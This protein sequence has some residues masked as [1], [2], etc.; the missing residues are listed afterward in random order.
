MMPNIRVFT[1]TNMQR[2]GLQNR[3]LRQLRTMGCQVLNTTLDPHLTIE[4][5]PATAS[6]LL[7]RSK[8]IVRQRASSGSDAVVSVEV[9]GCLVKWTEAKQ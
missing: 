6:S 4:V 3:V 1:P 2:L 7:R 8:C 5:K 9:N